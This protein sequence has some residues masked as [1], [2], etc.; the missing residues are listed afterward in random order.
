MVIIRSLVIES[1]CGP[2]F[3]WPLAI[4]LCAIELDEDI[5]C[6]RNKL[7]KVWL[8]S[9]CGEVQRVRKAVEY[10]GM[11]DNGCNL[12]DLLVYPG[13]LFKHPYLKFG[14]GKLL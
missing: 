8:A 12:L 13:G 1:T 9:Y 14:W 5:S 2:L 7:E 4:L 11:M 6:L 3:C 10:F